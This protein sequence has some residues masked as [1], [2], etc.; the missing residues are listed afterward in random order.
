M[1]NLYNFE[2]KFSKYLHSQ[3]YSDVTIRNYLSDL[4]H[5][6]GW[7][8][9]KINAGTINNKAPTDEF[10]AL[11]SSFDSICVQEYRSHLF[12]NEVPEKTINRRLSTLRSF[13]EFCVQQGWLKE[14]PTKHLL[15]I[16]QKNSSSSAL[17]GTEFQEFRAS[18]RNG[19]QDP[20]LALQ[21]ESDVQEFIQYLSSNSPKIIH[22]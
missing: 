9:I 5:F 6:F 14:N 16:S 18:L 12:K 21:I 11:Q 3:A 4:R 2:P 17:Y 1:Y 20:A 10:G 7:L 13:S 22:D 19:I 15:N 8:T